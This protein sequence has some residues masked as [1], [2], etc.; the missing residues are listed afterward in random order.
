MR[1][2]NGSEIWKRRYDIATDSNRLNGTS[3]AGDGDGVYSASYSHNAHGSMTSMPHLALMNWDHFDQLRK[4]SAAASGQPTTYYTYNAAGQRVRKVTENTSSVKTKERIYLGD[5]EVYRTYSSG[6]LVDET[7]TLHVMDDQKR[8]AMVETKTVDSGQTVNDPTHLLRYQL[9]DHLGSACVETD[10]DG[11]VITYEEYFP[12]GGTAF[13]SE[14]GGQRFKRYRYTGKEKD[15]ETG[16]YYHGARYYAPWLARWSAADPIG[17]EGGINLFAYVSNNPVMYFDP[18]GTDDKEALENIDST[19]NDSVVTVEA[20]EANN[21]YNTYDSRM[22]ITTSDGETKVIGPVH[23]DE[24]IKLLSDAEEGSIVKLEM[25]GHGSPTNIEFGGELGV[26]LTLFGYERN[27]NN[28]IRLYILEEKNGNK[29]KVDITELLNE[30]LSKDAVVSLDACY[31]AHANWIT[32]LLFQEERGPIFGLLHGKD[33]NL[34]QAMSKVLPD[35]T[36]YGDIMLGFNANI[37]V[38]WG[39]LTKLNG[40]LEIRCF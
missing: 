6:N 32:Q 18:S 31:T 36:V 33:I 21:G 37:L 11:A 20:N 14:S 39:H 34:A 8:V 12:F 9:S 29:N 30:K 2:A 7:Q 16:L 17:L 40:R 27:K 19:Y 25:T 3:L 13:H 15:D 22:R 10:G 5:F 35:R 38:F 26:N 24:F 23:K 28:E 1:H 4:S